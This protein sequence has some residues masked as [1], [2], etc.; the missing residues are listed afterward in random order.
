MSRIVIE[1]IVIENQSPLAIHSGGRE[2]GFDT[3]IAKDWNSLPYIPATS[4]VG[5]WRSVLKSMNLDI[6]E[7]RWFGSARGNGKASRIHVSDGLLL[8]S[9]Y[10]ISYGIMSLKA[11]ESDAIY[12]KFQNEKSAVRERCRINYRGASKHEGK[13]DE[14]IIPSGM[15]FVFD[16]R[17]EIDSDQEYKEFR[18][19][20]RG[21]ASRGFSLGSGV[22]NGHGDM[23]IVGLAEF[24]RD[25]SA[26]TDY[27]AFSGEMRKFLSEENI[28]R[29]ADDIFSSDIG[30]AESWKKLAELHLK[31]D[32]SWRIGNIFK[33]KMSKS[34]AEE[35]VSWRDGGCDF[36]ERVVICGSSI[37]GIIAHRTDY[38][39]RKLKME[40]ESDKSYS[41]E[42]VLP[43][44]FR[45]CD[46]SAP[47]KELFGTADG[48]DGA[49]AGLIVVD[50]AVVENAGQTIKRTHNRIDVFSRGVFSGALFSEERIY[51]PEFSLRLWLKGDFSKRI[52]DRLVLEALYRT[53]TDIKEGFLPIS[54]GNG[55]QAG[56]LSLKEDGKSMFDCGLLGMGE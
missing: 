10:R 8:N 36:K 13:F 42:S 30:D 45:N 18:G 2:L 21:L 41:A 53:I 25:M 15:R 49:K 28:P 47:L 44:D 38:H 16:I 6:D 20:L 35:Y 43:N 40:R 48:N 54:T 22:T 17:T 5:V 50:D 55:R 46:I 19:M 39:Y 24:N 32:D 23:K 26:I 14:S 9:H 27:A 7:S 1:R 31:A 11:R 37:K 56:T 12:E 51:R 3:Q 4:F 34:Y 29:K 52:S 33:D